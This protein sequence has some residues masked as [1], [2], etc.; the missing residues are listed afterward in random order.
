MFNSYN[1]GGYLMW[2]LRDYP[3]F[4]D[5]RTDLYSDEI[6]NQ[7]LQV[8]NAKNGWQTV[9]DKWDINLILIE[10]TW[11]I[12]KVLPN[13]GWKIFYQDNTAVLFGR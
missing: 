4:V 13:A 5:G 11:P 6:I 12:V 10:P 7:W 1:W 3:V 2:T 9:L 8:V